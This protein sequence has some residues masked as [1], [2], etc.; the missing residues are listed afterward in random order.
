MNDEAARQGRPE[1]STITCSQHTAWPRCE[2]CGQRAPTGELLE[3][4]RLR[5]CVG[6]ALG[7]HVIARRLTA[8]ERA[9]FVRMLRERQ[10]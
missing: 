10:A 9:E 1:P 7:R 8:A 4:H 5:R 6:P 2:A 3:R